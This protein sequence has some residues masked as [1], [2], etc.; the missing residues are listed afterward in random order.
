MKAKLFLL[1]ALANWTAVV[2]QMSRIVVGGE[3]D[4]RERLR[5]SVRE[6]ARRLVAR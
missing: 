4:D 3:T 1:I 6:A 2:P 5:A